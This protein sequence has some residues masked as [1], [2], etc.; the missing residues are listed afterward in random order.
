[1]VRNTEQAQL[2]C[3]ASVC[4]TDQ[5]AH[6]REAHKSQPVLH[7]GQDEVSQLVVREWTVFLLPLWN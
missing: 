2:Y 4:S 3:P 6:V 1:M 7:V 5:A